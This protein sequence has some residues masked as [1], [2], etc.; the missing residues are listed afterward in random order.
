MSIRSTGPVLNGLPTQLVDTDPDETQ[1]WL[2]SFDAMVGHPGRNRA[3]D[4][5]LLLLDRARQQIVGVP[6][7]TTTDYI[8]T[9]LLYTSRC[10]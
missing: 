1:E 5:M 9:F 7:L 3:R 4:L 8:N 10:V 2:E 6:S